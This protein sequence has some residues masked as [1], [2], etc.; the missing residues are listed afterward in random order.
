MGI[1][2]T[3]SPR[4]FLKR[5]AACGL[6]CTEE[7][8]PFSPM[9]GG[10]ARNVYVIPAPDKLTFNTALI[11]GV[12]C[13]IPAI[14]SLAFT[15]IQDL[16]NSYKRRFD[17][18]DMRQDLNQHISGTNNFTLRNLLSMEGEVRR[19]YQYWIEVPLFGT[20]VLGILVLGELNFFSPQVSYETEPFAS[21][22]KI[23]IVPVDCI[24]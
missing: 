6:K 12:G 17:P 19:R 20:S 13:C 8:P 15:S 18:E 11:I 2:L 3:G 16:E 10:A 23:L 5:A 24:I 9:R 14:L 1:P 4:D 7:D 22:G 21:I